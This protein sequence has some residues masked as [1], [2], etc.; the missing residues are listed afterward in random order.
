[1]QTEE[2]NSQ[3]ADAQQMLISK[4]EP[5]YNYDDWRIQ[6][7]AKKT[8][9]TAH[10]YNVIMARQCS[11]HHDNRS[12]FLFQALPVSY[13]SCICLS[14][15]KAQGQSVQHIGLYFQTPVFSVITRI[16]NMM[17]ESHLRFSFSGTYF[18]QVYSNSNGSQSVEKEGGSLPTST[19]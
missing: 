7:E 5:D 6:V 8:E 11:S 19:D 4:Y 10:L 14:I 1:M 16:N 17:H 18:R 15:N 3:S 9:L 12:Q 13:Q 2:G